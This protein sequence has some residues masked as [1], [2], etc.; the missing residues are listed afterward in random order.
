MCKSQSC[1]KKWSKM[2]SNGLVDISKIR[3]S[4]VMALRI[5]ILCLQ[6]NETKQ[7]DVKQW[8]VAKLKNPSVCGLNHSEWTL[9]KWPKTVCTTSCSTPSPREIISPALFFLEKWC[10]WQNFSIIDYIHDKWSIWVEN[11]SKVS[12]LCSI[13][14]NGLEFICKCGYQLA[15]KMQPITTI[16]TCWKPICLLSSQLEGWKLAPITTW[17][18]D[19]RA[20][21]YPWGKWW[22]WCKWSTRMKNWIIFI[23]QCPTVNF[24]ECLPGEGTFSLLIGW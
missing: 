24:V 21:P 22:E 23:R 16:F 17:R 5:D 18:W 10:Q 8:D 6:P 19:P 7:D 20:V 1:T 15:G 4:A 12:T 14:Q 13:A 9:V 2:G 3:D 11:L